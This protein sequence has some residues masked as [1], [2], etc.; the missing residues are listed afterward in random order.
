LAFPATALSATSLG[1]AI[2][3]SDL[4]NFGGVATQV[5]RQGKEKCNALCDPVG[6]QDLQATK[7]SLNGCNVKPGAINTSPSITDHVSRMPP[8]L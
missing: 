1:G 3:M 5:L 7:T 2:D 4:L 6:Q 8:R